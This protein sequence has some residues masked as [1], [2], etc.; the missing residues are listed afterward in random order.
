VQQIRLFS[1]PTVFESWYPHF[2]ILN[3][4]IGEEALAMA[5][6][7]ARFFQS[8]RHVV[9]Q[10]IGLLIQEHNEANWQIYQEFRRCRTFLAKA[11]AQHQRGWGRAAIC[12]KFHSCLYHDLSLT[13]STHLFS[14]LYPLDSRLG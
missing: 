8:Y 2:T 4:Y 14:G 1:S 7:L 5:S 12:F 11:H 3:P 10:T 13:L 6:R 9:V